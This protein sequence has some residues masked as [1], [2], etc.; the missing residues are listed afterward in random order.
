MAHSNCDCWIEFDA[1]IQPPKY[2]V[3]ANTASISILLLMRFSAEIQV[4]DCDAN[5]IAALVGACHA[6]VPSNMFTAEV[7]AG[8]P[9]VKKA[10]T[11]HQKKPVKVRHP[12]N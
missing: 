1:A 4:R 7:M 3:I 10:V 11:R 8:S 6:Y 2:L 5:D 12:P 9:S